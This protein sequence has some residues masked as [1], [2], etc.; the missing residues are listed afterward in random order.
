MIPAAEVRAFVLG[1]VCVSPTPLSVVPDRQHKPKGA[2]VLFAAL[3]LGFDLARGH[4]WGLFSKRI[5]VQVGLH[6]NQRH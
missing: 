6:P 3:I 1:W 5:H 2:V 4:V